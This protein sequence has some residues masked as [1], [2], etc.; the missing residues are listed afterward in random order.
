WVAARVPAQFSPLQILSRDARR[1]GA[2]IDWR[3]LAARVLGS[4]RCAP[5]PV[6]RALLL[7][8]IRVDQAFRVEAVHVPHEAGLGD[9][10]AKQLLHAGGKAAGPRRR[11]RKRHVL[12]LA[13]PRLAV[14]RRDPET[15][16]ATQARPTAVLE[17]AGQHDDR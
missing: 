9:A 14:L 10:V 13:Q 7:R 2:K 4:P 15:R 17:G 12:D 16:T 6:L 5:L 8:E 1:P 3:G 11:H